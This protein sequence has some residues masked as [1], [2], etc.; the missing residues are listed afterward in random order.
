MRPMLPPK[1][2]E[3]TQYRKPNRLNSVSLTLA[4]I[5][6]LMIYF[7]YAF[8]PLWLMR[9]RARGVLEDVLPELYRLNLRGDSIAKQEIPKMQKDLLVLM[10]KA[11]IRSKIE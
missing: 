8:W 2:R 10:K 11:G 3:R 4:A 9:V 6:G 1:A 7:G 5:A